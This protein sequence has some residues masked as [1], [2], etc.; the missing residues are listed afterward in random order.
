MLRLFLILLIM[1]YASFCDIKTMEIPDK[2]F[3]LIM[4]LAQRPYIKASL[5]I[6]GLHLL[7]TLLCVLI[8]KTVPMGFGDAKILFALCFSTG[9]ALTVSS[10]VFASLFSGIYS[11]LIL[12]RNRFSKDT[13]RRELPFMPFITAGFIAASVRAFL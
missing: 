12:A 10:F 11:V 6:L 4:L 13:L 8:A 1:V 2:C 5:I 7:F 3:I 9:P